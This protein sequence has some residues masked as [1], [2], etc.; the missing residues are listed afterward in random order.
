MFFFY[1]CAPVVLLSVF[2]AG[3]GGQKGISICIYF[4]TLLYIYI[5]Y[6]YL[7][8]KDYGIH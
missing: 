4:Y 6:Y 2:L 8:Q 5:T 1:Y 7:K 3:R